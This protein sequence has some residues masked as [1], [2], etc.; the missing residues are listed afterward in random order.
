MITHIRRTKQSI[1]FPSFFIY[2]YQEI[3]KKKGEADLPHQ[4]QKDMK[5]NKREN[6]LFPTVNGV[7]FALPYI[8]PVI[9]SYIPHTPSFSAGTK[10]LTSVSPS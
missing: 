7:E 1:M 2:K 9:V 4:S 8:V 3:R 5:E 6:Y 10:F